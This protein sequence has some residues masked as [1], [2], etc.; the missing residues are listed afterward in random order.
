M[1][2]IAAVV[3]AIVVMSIGVAGTSPDAPHNADAATVKVGTGARTTLITGVILFVLASIAAKL[4]TKYCARGDSIKNYPKITQC[5]A[6]YVEHYYLPLD[7]QNK[8][9]KPE[10]IEPLSLSSSYR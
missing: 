4:I 8:K 2:P 10:H 3:F 6:Y 7:V 9:T 5:I 1:S